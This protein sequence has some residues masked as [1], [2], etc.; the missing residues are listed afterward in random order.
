M[1]EQPIV[2]PRFKVHYQQGSD[3]RRRRE[4]RAQRRNAGEIGQPRQAW[5][6]GRKIAPA[7]TTQSVWAK[8]AEKIGVS[9][10]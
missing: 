4:L 2:V 3:A 10:L 6:P 9:S 7:V 1:S 8:V 5:K